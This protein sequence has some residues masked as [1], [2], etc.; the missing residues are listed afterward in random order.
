ME[1]ETADRCRGILW[2]ATVATTAGVCA[3]ALASPASAV[4][5]QQYVEVPQCQPA[6]SQ[7][8]PQEPEVNF[9]AGNGGRGEIVDVQFTANQ[10]H[11]SDII[12]HVSIDGYVPSLLG[13]VGPGQT[14][15][16]GFGVGPGNHVLRV[17]AEGITG[18]CNTGALSSWGGTVRIDS[19]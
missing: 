12:V 13:R 2:A 1:R 19:A 7:V 5:I 4:S 18:G 8:C 17:R 10:N 16:Q 14:A 11:C 9:T 6:T 3:L 15:K